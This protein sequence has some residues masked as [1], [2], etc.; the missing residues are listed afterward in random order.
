MFGR[1]WV[2]SRRAR[3]RDPVRS[4]NKDSILGIESFGTFYFV[5]HAFSFVFCP[6]SL[7]WKSSFTLKSPQLLPEV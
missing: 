6:V 2:A 3:P 7:R 4:K 1:G 5:Q